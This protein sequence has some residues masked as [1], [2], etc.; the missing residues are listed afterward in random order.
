[1][2]FIHSFRRTHE[3]EKAEIIKNHY[4]KRLILS[5]DIQAQLEFAT[6][7]GNAW[8]GFYSE[9][10]RLKREIRDIMAEASCVNQ[11]I[12]EGDARCVY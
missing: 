9:K 11:L 2:K 7:A 3:R 1:M 12:C 6:D 8:D 10:E 4:E 5:R